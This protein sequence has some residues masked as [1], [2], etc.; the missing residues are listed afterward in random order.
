MVDATAASWPRGSLDRARHKVVD[1]KLI[2]VNAGTVVDCGPP[3]GRLARCTSLFVSYMS[4]LVV[5][6]EKRQND[7]RYHRRIGLLT[8]STLIHLLFT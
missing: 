8:P 4:L 7:H 3:V 5:S 6:P 1:G 2:T